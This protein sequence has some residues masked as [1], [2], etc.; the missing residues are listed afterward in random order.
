MV[1]DIINTTEMIDRLHY[2]IHI[3]NRICNADSV[4]LEDISCLLVC[5]STAFYMVGIVGKVNLSPVVDTAF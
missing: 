5:Q 4:R 3:D 2:I 1:Y